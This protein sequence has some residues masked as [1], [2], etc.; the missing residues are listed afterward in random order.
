MVKLK[1]YRCT[2]HAK[3]G[4]GATTIWSHQDLQEFVRDRISLLSKCE[5][6]H[7]PVAKYVRRL[8]FIMPP[9]QSQ[10]Q[11]ENTLEE[12]WRT[13]GPLMGVSCGHSGCKLGM[14]AGKLHEVSWTNYN[15][16]GWN[17]SERCIGMYAPV[18]CPQ[19][20]N[21]HCKPPRGCC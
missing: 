17:T 6:E 8:Q 12:I 18:L 3:E 11:M 13:C 5:L 15:V 20:L 7:V 21:W 16:F 1:G 9:Q 10:Q 19:D 14:L 2:L 4:P